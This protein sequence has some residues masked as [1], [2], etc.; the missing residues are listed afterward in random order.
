[1]LFVR[2]GSVTQNLR[3]VVQTVTA[4]RVCQALAPCAQAVLCFLRLCRSA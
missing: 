1:M 4:A 2:A 3:V